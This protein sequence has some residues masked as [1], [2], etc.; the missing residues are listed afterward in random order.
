M[1]GLYRQKPNHAHRHDAILLGSQGVNVWAQPFV[2]IWDEGI[3]IFE[4]VGQ[5][6][7]VRLG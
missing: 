2:G 3:H 4:G 6:T 1:V 7:N 5:L